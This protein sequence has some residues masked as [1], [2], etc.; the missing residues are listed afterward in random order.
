MTNYLSRLG[1]INWCK[2]W[3]ILSISCLVVNFWGE[4]GAKG[5]IFEEYFLRKRE[6]TDL[7][8]FELELSEIYLKRKW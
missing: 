3:I 4:K 5:T 6:K 1:I 7:F 2:N 8:E